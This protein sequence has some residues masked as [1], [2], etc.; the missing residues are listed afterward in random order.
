MSLCK[1]QAS[2]CPSTGPSHQPRNVSFP[3]I[4]FGK[5]KI[6]LD[7]STVLGLTSGDGYTGMTLLRVLFVLHVSV[8]VSKTNFHLVMLMLP[9]FPVNFRIG[10]MPPLLF[11][12]TRVLPV[13]RKL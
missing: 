7:L 6:I 1:L 9:S 13:I 11:V 2:Q 5:S 10:K 12:P 3:R 8:H 4:P